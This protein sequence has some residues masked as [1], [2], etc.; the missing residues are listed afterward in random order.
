[1]RIRTA[2]LAAS[3][4]VTSAFADAQTVDVRASIGPTLV[5][6]GLSV[7]GDVAFAPVPA[8]AIVGGVER[9]RLNSRTHRDER[10][11]VTHFRGGALSIATIGLRLQWPQPTRVRPYLLAGYGAGRSRP[12]V[13]PTFPT[14]VTNDVRAVYAGGGIAVA[15]GAR[16]HVTVDARMI[17]GDE[18]N[19]LLVLSPLRA[20]LAW[21]F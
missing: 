1:M 4:A 9:S 5:D 7:A 13:N 14:P 11:G 10:G 6:A 12:T 3:L 15:L 16:L 17:V 2:V 21:R 20:G 19:E 8:L 18:G